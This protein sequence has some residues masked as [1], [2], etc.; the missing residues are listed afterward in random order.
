ML[1]MLCCLIYEINMPFVGS[2][3][4]RLKN[5]S[6]SDLISLVCYRKRGAVKRNRN[7][8]METKRTKGGEKNIQKNKMVQSP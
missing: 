6:C 2:D 1:P 7:E 3:V 8:G 5:D 4:T